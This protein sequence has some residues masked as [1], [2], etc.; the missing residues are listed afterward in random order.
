MYREAGITLA[1]FFLCD[2]A[3]GTNPTIS[4]SPNKTARYAL[5]PSTTASSGADKGAERSPSRRLKSATRPV[6]SS[7]RSLTRRRT[8]TGRGQLRP[9]TGGAPSPRCGATTATKH[10]RHSWPPT[11]RGAVGGTRGCTD[12]APPHRQGLPVVGSVPWRYT[13]RGHLPS[14]RGRRQYRQPGCRITQVY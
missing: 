2:V 13:T 12:L 6:A 1:I 10:T 11:A 5:M 8:R 3:R 14:G 4:A 7:N 9:P